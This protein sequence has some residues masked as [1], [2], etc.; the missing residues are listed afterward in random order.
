MGISQ[1]ASAA[2]LELVREKRST[3]FSL[4]DLAERVGVTADMMS[5]SRTYTAE[6]G[7]PLGFSQYVVEA[8]HGLEKA[9][10][11]ADRISANLRLSN[12]AIIQA[13]SALH[14]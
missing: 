5:T 2:A 7:V 3:H 4:R 12:F 14:S 6:E 13:C 9:T 11:P 8:G 1:R 10:K